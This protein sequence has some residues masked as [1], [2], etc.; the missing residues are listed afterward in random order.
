MATIVTRTG[1]GSELTHSEVDAN[2]TNLNNAKIETNAA[3]RAAVEAA[4]DSNVFADADHT[5]LNG[6]EASA[7]ADQSNAEIRA[8]VEAAG[9]SNIFTDSDHTKLN[10]I[11]ASA[12]ADQSK[13][14]IEALGID[15]PAANL[16]GTIAAARLST[17]TTQAESDDSTN[18]AT[19]AYVVD[20]ITTLIGGAPSTLDDLNELAAAINDDSAYNSTLTTALATK[21]PKS[22]GA[23]TGAVTTNSTFDGVDIAARDAVLTSTTTTAG[24]ALPKAGGAVTGAITTNSTFDGRDV[25]ADGVLATNAL[26]KSGGAL[27]GAVTTNSTFDGVDIATRDAVLTSTTT[28]AGAALPKAGGAMSG[29]ISTAQNANLSFN[30]NGGVGNGAVVFMGDGQSSGVAG[31]FKLNCSANSHGIIIQG[32]AHSAGASYTLTMPTTDGAANQVLKSDG[33]GVLSWVDQ[34]ADTNTTYSVGDNGLTTNNFTDADHTKLNGIASGANNYT[35]PNHS[36]EISSSG[37]GATIIADDIVDEANLKV[38]NGPSDGY[39]L[40]AQSGAT[41]GL[42]WAAQPSTSLPS[43]AGAGKV[44]TINAGNSASVW[45]TPSGGGVSEDTVIALTIALG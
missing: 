24:A 40:T 34:T 13:S 26:P 19:T 20:K 7:T 38:S 27:T 16:T 18:I 36:G 3:V 6:I 4:A 32:P 29:A 8:A 5:K 31:R 22:G 30:P 2:F 44:L 1:K 28:T 43:L 35:A 14:D 23:F 33:A 17:A 42:T 11:E 10:G 15:L 41:G 9:D 45:A 37:D 12:T 39:M 25:A 21:M